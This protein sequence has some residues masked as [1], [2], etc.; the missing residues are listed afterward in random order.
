MKPRRRP[1]HDVLGC[2]IPD[3][4]QIGRHQARQLGRRQRALDE[5]GPLSR[6]R[7]YEEAVVEGNV[8]DQG[9]PIRQLSPQRLGLEGGAVGAQE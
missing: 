4:G 9:Q 3:C 5:M 2:A 8:I 1:A 7:P 6:Q